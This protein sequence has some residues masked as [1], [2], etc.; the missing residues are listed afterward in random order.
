MNR[1]WIDQPQA[2]RSGE[3]L[4]VAKLAAYLRDR[5][6]EPVDSLDVVQFPRGYS[7]LTYLLKWGAR[8]LVLRRPPFGARIKSAHDMGREFRILSGLQGIYARAPKPLVYCEDESVL[9]AP[10]YVMERVTGVILRAQPPP[11]FAAA[12]ELMRRLS[13]SF[14]DNLVAIHA[15][16][17]HAAGLADLGR[18]EGYVARQVEGWTKRY[19]NART[20]DIA[21]MDEL[22]TWLDAHRPGESGACLIHNDYK[23][24]N[25]V[26]DPADLPHILA[27]L[28]WEM[29]TLGDPLMDLG[30]T[31]GYWVDADDPPEWRQQA[32]GVT[33]LP[34]NLSREQLVE[35]YAA[36]SGR[37]VANPVFY[38]A[39]GL[40]KI[41]VIVQ[42][43]YA[44]YRQGVTKD[45]RF[46]RLIQVVHGASRMAARAI[47]QERISGL[48]VC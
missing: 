45:E 2:P 24:D 28:D 1:E 7:N 19:R 16:D 26:L 34:G 5:L 10:F 8:E 22:A 17:C 37:S 48:A 9:G 13:E 30:S 46:A 27:T 33:T 20:D 32:F 14:I 6:A 41:A 29:S 3:E 47:E 38:Y 40:F 36:Q 18:P 35:R 44:R 15:V 31:L 43:I 21:A 39:Y 25:L 4:D 23:Y 42:Q 11:G 12:P